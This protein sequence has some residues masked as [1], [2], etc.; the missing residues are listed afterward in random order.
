M[1]DINLEAPAPAPKADGIWRPEW[2]E[3][4][5]TF[6]CSRHIAPD[7]KLTRETYGARM[8]GPE[9]ARFSPLFLF[10]LEDAKAQCDGLNAKDE[11]NG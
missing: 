4:R 1:R 8:N 6:V 3:W 5:Q 10:R 2:V 9:G 11:A 7:G